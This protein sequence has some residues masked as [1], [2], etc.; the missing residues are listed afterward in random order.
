V[1]EAQVLRTDEKY[2]TRKIGAYTGSISVVI[3]KSI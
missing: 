2:T 3:K 1:K